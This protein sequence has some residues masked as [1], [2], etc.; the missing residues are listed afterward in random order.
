MCTWE[1]NI[2]KDLREREWE[3]VGW[4]HLAQDKNQWLYF[5]NIEVTFMSHERRGIF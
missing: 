2:R 5:V 4:M 1:D 3:F